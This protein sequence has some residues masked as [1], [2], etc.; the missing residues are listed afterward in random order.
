MTDNKQPL[1]KFARTELTGTSAASPLPTEFKLFSFGTNKTLHG[2]FVFD[3]QSAAD[4]MNEFKR[5]GVDMVIDLNHDSLDRDKRLLRADSADAMGWFVPEVRPDGS[6]WATAVRWSSEGER[7]L[8]GRL[9]RFTSPAAHYDPATMRVVSL[10]NCALCSDPA[11]FGNA[12]LLAASAGSKTTMVGAR[13]PGEMKRKLALVAER[14]G[15]NVSHLIKLAVDRMTS[16]IVGPPSELLTDLLAA[17]S[18]P[19]TATPDDIKR[20]LFDLVDE[21][22]AAPAP[23][24]VQLSAETLRRIKAKGLTV[25][26]FLAQREEIAQAMRR[27]KG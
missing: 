14:R 12:P 18:L 10:V 5:R 3:A 19:P 13:V 4:V 6:L 17:M 20:A 2:E 22:F 7:R 16:K 8:R 26:Q 21:R 24:P 15:M 25:E 27:R 1:A 23:A 9:Q 11:T